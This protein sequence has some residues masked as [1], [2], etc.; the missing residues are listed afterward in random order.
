[1]H[2]AWRLLLWSLAAAVMEPYGAWRLL[3][4]F[5]PGPQPSLW[6]SPNPSHPFL[7]LYASLIRHQPLLVLSDLFS[8][9]GPCLPFTLGLPSL[10]G[11]LP[12]LPGP[13]LSPF[14]P[15]GS[16]LQ[17]SSSPGI[18]SCP[19]AT[20]LLYVTVPYLSSASPPSYSH[21]SCWF[22]PPAF[23]IP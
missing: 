12:P 7:S 5:L 20:C 14:P 8:L 13:R 10:F 1:M 16:F 9:L 3:L 22:V 4:S 17:L 18:S 21:F 2:G 6:R 15:A 11:V 19:L 23:L